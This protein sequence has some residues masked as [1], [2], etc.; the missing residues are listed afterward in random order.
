M[1]ILGRLLSRVA[2]AASLVSLICVALMMLHVTA[3]VV[4]RFTMNMPLPG[5]ITIVSH[6]YM[7][8]LGFLALALAEDRNAHI[9]V[10]VVYDLLPGFARRALAILARLVSAAAFG[11]VAVRGWEVAQSKTAIGASVQQGSDVIVVWPTY[12]AIPI[13][14]GLMALVALAKVFEPDAGDAAPEEHLYE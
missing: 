8:L 11:L 13:G 14:A 9:S 10:E 7:V 12:W 3:D 6:Y 1:T 2:G 5:T 4:G